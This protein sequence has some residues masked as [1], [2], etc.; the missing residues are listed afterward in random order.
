MRDRVSVGCWC[1][2]RGRRVNRSDDC[3]CYDE[4]ALSCACAWGYCPRCKGRV[5]SLDVLRRQEA[6]SKEAGA[7]EV[8]R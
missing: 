7:F 3:A 2:W 1:G 8:S 4:W 5:T 6:W